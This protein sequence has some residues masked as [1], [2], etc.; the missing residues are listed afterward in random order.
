MTR[1]Y[2]LST[3]A[4]RIADRD[5]ISFDDAI[6]VLAQDAVS[7]N[8]ADYPVAILANLPM[9]EHNDGSLEYAPLSQSDA[10]ARIAALGWVV[11]PRTLIARY[12][13][14]GC[15]T[16][17]LRCADPREYGRD[18]LTFRAA[19]VHIADLSGVAADL[20]AASASACGVRVVFDALY[21]STFVGGAK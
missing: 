12:E 19:R 8:L 11:N 20:N 15:G 3:F 5:G 1:T 9:I 21:S 4:T 2:P 10:I 14:K 17:H 7:I 13:V 18:N 16:L 6:R